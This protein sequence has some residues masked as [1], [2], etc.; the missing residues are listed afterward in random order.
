MSTH[1]VSVGRSR[2]PAYAVVAAVVAAI[3]IAVLAVA[4]LRFDVGP[5]GRA[6]STAEVATPSAADMPMPE[7]LKSYVAPKGSDMPTPEWLKSY[8]A[9]KA[10]VTMPTPGWL[11]HYLQLGSSSTRPVNEGLR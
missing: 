3:A 11:E 10:S 5:F 2:P 9:P 7:W 8:L 4:D 6:D 1:T